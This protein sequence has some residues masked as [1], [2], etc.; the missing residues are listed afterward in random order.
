VKLT[1]KVLSPESRFGSSRGYQKTRR[2]Q[3][4][5]RIGERAFLSRGLRPDRA[6]KYEHA[7]TREIHRAARMEREHRD[8]SLKSG[9]IGGARWKSEAPILAAK[10]GNSGGAKGGRKGMAASVDMS[11]TLGRY[12]HDK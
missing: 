7:V 10:P 3:G 12:R 2:Q 1:L 5:T 8:P 4:A 6:S 9:G 11:R